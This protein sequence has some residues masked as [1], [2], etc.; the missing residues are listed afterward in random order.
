MIYKYE[1][2][3]DSSSFF[4]V[5]AL[6]IHPLERKTY[7]EKR[8]TLRDFAIYWQQNAEKMAYDWLDNIN[9]SIFFKEYGKKYGLLRE[10]RDNGI[11]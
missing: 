11:I 1:L 3:Q 6:K 4:T 9:W 10:F 5:E 8:R 2:T 7:E